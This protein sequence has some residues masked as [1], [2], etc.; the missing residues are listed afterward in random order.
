MWVVGAAATSCG[1]AG[2]DGAT[3]WT[4]GAQ[5]TTKPIANDAFMR[6]SK[7]ADV[8]APESN[9]TDAFVIACR[10]DCLVRSARPRRS[11]PRCGKMHAVGRTTALGGFGIIALAVGFEARCILFV[12][13]SPTGDQF[14]QTCGIA[15]PTTAC[16]MCMTNTCAAQLTACCGDPSCRTALGDVD[17]CSEAGSCIFDMT[18]TTGASLGQCINTCTSCN[19]EPATVIE[20]GAQIECTTDTA[21]QDCDCISGLGES[22]TSRCDV[23]TFS[24]AF[25]CADNTWPAAGTSCSC[26]PVGCTA[27]TAGNCTCGAALSSNNTSSCNSGVGLCCGLDGT[28][29]CDPNANTCDDLGGGTQVLDCTLATHIGCSQGQHPVSNCSPE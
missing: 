26:S 6:R 5:A 15:N 13:S 17:E 27:Y 12:D 3:V 22:N 10:I 4:A 25:C 9:K 7:A 16:G 2:G 24:N 21:N 11:V 20:A 14:S 29:S 8:P 19:A 28:C 18:S 23:T 1:T